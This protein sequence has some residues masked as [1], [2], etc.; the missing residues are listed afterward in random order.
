MKYGFNMMNNMNNMD[1]IISMCD[2]LL[3]SPT[4]STIHTTCARSHMEHIHHNENMK[5]SSKY[6]THNLEDTERK[7]HIINRTDVEN[8]S[9]YVQI[10]TDILSI[11]EVSSQ[12]KHSDVNDLSEFEKM[13]D[14]Y[15]LGLFYVKVNYKLS[16]LEFFGLLSKIPFETLKL[17]GLNQI[18]YSQLIQL[19]GEQSHDIV[20]QLMV[21]GDYFKFWSL[22]NP[23]DHMTHT[24][25][26]TKLMLSEM[27]YLSIYISPNF[28]DD[29]QRMIETMELSIP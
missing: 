25:T 10:W 24:H 12:F 14:L 2:V 5:L 1:Y 3:Q 19:F 9:N 26:I 21:L 8:L 28:L 7:E 6:N 11:D 15:H 4:T 17:P 20:I 16:I 18:P 29:C 13:N 22:I 27:G 23:Y